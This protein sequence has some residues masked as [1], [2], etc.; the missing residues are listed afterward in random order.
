[1]LKG[2]SLKNIGSSIPKC[3]RAEQTSREEVMKRAEAQGGEG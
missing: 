2:V 1:M 3:T